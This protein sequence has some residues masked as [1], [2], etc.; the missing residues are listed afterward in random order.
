[1]EDN[2]SR[3]APSLGQP[4]WYRQESD[5]VCGLLALVRSTVRFL[6]SRSSD[7]DPRI[8]PHPARQDRSPPSEGRPFSV[9]NSFSCP[10]LP[11]FF[12]LLLSVLWPLPTFFCYCRGNLKPV[13]QRKKRCILANPWRADFQRPSHIVSVSETKRNYMK[14]L[15]PILGQHPFLQGLKSEHLDVLARH[16]REVEFTPRQVIFRQNDAAYEFF[17]IMEGEVTV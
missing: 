3:K 1:M 4:T 13:Q 8:S 10:H 17:L 9:G 15:K 11:P 7:H 12:V 16:A 2:R 5:S 6:F 14:D